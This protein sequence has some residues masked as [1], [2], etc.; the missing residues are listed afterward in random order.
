MRDGTWRRALPSYRLRWPPP[1]VLLRAAG[2]DLTATPR[3]ARGLPSLEA[4]QMP[5][6]QAYRTQNLRNADLLRASRACTAATSLDLRLR[7][8]RGCASLSGYAWR[9]PAHC[10]VRSRWREAAFTSGEHRAP[11]RRLSP[12]SPGQSVVAAAKDTS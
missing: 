3:T 2:R 7:E 8:A 10:C 11:A 4:L 12:R 5:T 9:S 6:W 1:K